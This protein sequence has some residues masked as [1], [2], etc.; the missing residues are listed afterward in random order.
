M[1]THLIDNEE[2]IFLFM[3]KLSACAKVNPNVEP[4]KTIF[5]N[6]ISAVLVNSPPAST[7]INSKTSTATKAPMGSIKIPSHFNT[8]DTSFFNGMC[9]KIGVITVGPV[10]IINA[11]NKYEICQLKLNIKC[12][13]NAAPKKVTKDPRVISFVITGPTFFYFTQFLK[14]IRL[15]IKI[16]LIASDT[17]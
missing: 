5:P 16:I 8:V 2:P 12:A 15:Q 17:K 1:Q 6:S 14:L 7:L 13:A 11:E 4:N 10:T 3:M 9:R